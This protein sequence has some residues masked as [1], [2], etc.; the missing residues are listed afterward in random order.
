MSLDFIVLSVDFRGASSL[1]LSLSCVSVDF[2]GARVLTLWHQGRASP[3][4][5]RLLPGSTSR[6]PTS[7]SS[8]RLVLFPVRLARSWLCAGWYC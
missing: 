8:L 5:C 4:R 7:R 1:S 2:R 6:P 3:T